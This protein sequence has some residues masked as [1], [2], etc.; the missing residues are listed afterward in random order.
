MS[1]MAQLH[2][3]VVGNDIYLRPAA[4]FC[5]NDFIRHAQLLSLLMQ[6]VNQLIT[7]VVMGGNEYGK[8][9]Q[10]SLGC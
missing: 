3:L 8:H 4:I 2:N 1:A 5:H 10:A 9:I 7:S 6:V